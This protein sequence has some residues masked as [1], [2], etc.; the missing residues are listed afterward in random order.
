MKHKILVIIALPALVLTSCGGKK[1][2][3]SEKVSLKTSK[4]SASYAAGL[5]EGDNMMRM[6]QERGI[7]TL[8]DTGLFV[9][10]FVDYMQHH[11]QLN[12][13][14]AQNTLRAYFTAIS[15]RQMAKFKQDNAPKME[16]AKNWMAENGKRKEVTTTASGL[17]YEVLKKGSGPNV[18]IGDVLKV[19]YEGSFTN[20]EVFESS[21]ERGQPYE[22][23]LSAVGGVIQGWVEALQLMNKGAKFKVYIPYDLAYGEVGQAPA[24]KPYSNLIFTME[25]VDIKPGSA[26]PANQ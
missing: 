9:Q 17:Q 10:G 20:G 4:D 19:H 16:E 14:L 2:D 12:K 13:D 1:K 3:K 15:N 18:K 6:M 26:A 24:I 25:V 11:P 23:Q 8:L 5:T 7:D 22:F 21:Y